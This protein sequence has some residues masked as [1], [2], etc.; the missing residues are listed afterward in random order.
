VWLSDDTEE[1]T[2]IAVHSPQ[3]CTSQSGMPE[4]AFCAIALGAS[5]LTAFRKLE[6]RISVRQLSASTSPLLRPA[7]LAI[8]SISS[9]N[10][11]ST[12][13]IASR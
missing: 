6:G 10:A 1:L 8:P 9:S 5:S 2:A 11:Q 4:A 12:V 7:P 13:A 3:S